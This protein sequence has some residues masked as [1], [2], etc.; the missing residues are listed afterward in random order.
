MEVGRESV[1]DEVAHGMNTDDAGKVLLF[2]GRGLE[3]L[4][5][6]NPT[7]PRP[8]SL[9]TPFPSPPSILLL[10]LHLMSRPLYLLHS[11]F[12]SICPVHFH[13]S[14]M[15]SLLL[16]QLQ[17]PSA[18]TSPSRALSVTYLHLSQTISI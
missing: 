2:L 3:P 4:P 18:L 10:S 5:H 6:P 1:R 14:A 9:P 17:A 13:S 8:P 11:S 16:H 15:T 12:S 7:R